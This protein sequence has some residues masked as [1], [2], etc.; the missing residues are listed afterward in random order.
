VSVL[1]TDDEDLCRLVSRGLRLEGFYLVEELF[2]DPNQRVVICR[3]EHLGHERASLPEHLG[4]ESEGQ[5]SKF[6]LPIGILVPLGSYIGSS[7]VQYHICFKMLEFSFHL[8]HHTVLSDV[9]FKG[10]TSLDWLDGVQINT[11]LDRGHRHEFVSNLQPPSRGA[12]EVDQDLGS[13]Q[14]VILL[15]DLDELK[16]CS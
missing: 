14:K 11:Y 13:A 6:I 9:S 1:L 5:E 4:S 3:P 7:I 15:I 16:G 12:T 2:K 8:G 10:H